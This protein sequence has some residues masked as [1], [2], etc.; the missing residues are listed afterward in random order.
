MALPTLEKT[1]QFDCNIAIG[2]RGSVPT[3][4]PKPDNQDHL[5]N[6]KNALI[7][8][9]SGHWTVTSSSDGVTADLTDRWVDFEDLIWA[10][11][12]TP[13]SWIVLTNSATGVQL[14]FE[15]HNVQTYYTEVYMSVGGLY[16]TAGLVTTARPSCTDEV[17]LN[18]ASFGIGGLQAAW[19]GYL[20]VMMS[21]DGECTRAVTCRTNLAVGFLMSDAVK[22]PVS[23]WTSPVVGS[24]AGTFNS[25]VE[26]LTYAKYNDNDDEVWGYITTAFELYLTSEG[27]GATTIGESS[28]GTVADSQNSSWVMCPMGLASTTVNHVGRKGA[29]YDMWW[30]SVT[31]STG[32]SYP[33]DTSYQFAQFG[34]FILPFDGTLPLVS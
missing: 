15:C 11:T 14:C 24:C 25:T 30:G 12:T 22:S 9:A 5:W 33:N 13:H 16:A 4:A 21:T 3:A 29:L 18:P 27:Y 34:D 8:F 20:H 28:A 31:R 1:W 6:L 2:G 17:P 19:A 26:W 32:D 7:S 10:N 23:G